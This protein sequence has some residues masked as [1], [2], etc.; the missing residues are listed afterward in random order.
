[1]AI[2]KLVQLALG[3]SFGQLRLNFGCLDLTWSWATQTSRDL[4][5][6]LIGKSLEVVGSLAGL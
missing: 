3:W 1:M 5:K 4:L 2:E 6:G